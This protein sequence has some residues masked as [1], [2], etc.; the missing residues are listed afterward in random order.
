MI[1]PKTLVTGAIGLA[2]L[3]SIQV[4]LALEKYRPGQP[5]PVLWEFKSAQSGANIS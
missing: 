1:T 4:K 5:E 2:V 3:L